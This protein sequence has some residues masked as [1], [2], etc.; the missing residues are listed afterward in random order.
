M[1]HGAIYV[2]YNTQHYLEQVSEER[3]Q[4]TYTSGS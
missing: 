3:W 1:S 2:N 4:I